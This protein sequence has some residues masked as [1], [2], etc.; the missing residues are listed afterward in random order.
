MLSFG[1]YGRDFCIRAG[2]IHGDLALAWLLHCLVNMKNA[3]VSRAKT[4]I[5]RQLRFQN[6]PYQGTETYGILSNFV[7]DRFGNSKLEA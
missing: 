7:P 6:L 4:A 2:S 5:P 1:K 3:V